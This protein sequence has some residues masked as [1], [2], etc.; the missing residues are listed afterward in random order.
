MRIHRELSK[1]HSQKHLCQWSACTLLFIIPNYECSAN[2]LIDLNID[3]EPLITSVSGDGSLAVG[4]LRK[5][6]SNPGQYQPFKYDLPTRTLTTLNVEVTGESGYA[7]GISYDGTVILG[8]CR[9]AAATY[10]AAKWAADG[11]RTKLD[12]LTGAK[13]N[14]AH[15][16]S[17][18]KKVII[19]LSQDTSGNFRAVTWKNGATTATQLPDITGGSENSYAHG[20]SD[21]GSIIVGTVQSS[22]TKKNLA[23]KW[24]NNTVTSLGTLGGIGSVALSVSGDG[25]VIVGSA[26]TTT[27]TTGGVQ[28][29]HAYM[30]KD[31][32]MI[33]LGTLGGTNSLATAVSG[34]GAVIVGSAHTLDNETHAFQ[35]YD[36]VMKDL[37]TLGGLSSTAAAVSAD[38]KLILGRSQIAGGDWHVFMCYTDF[39]SKKMLD[40]DNTYETLEENHGQLNSLFNLQNMM[41]R[42]ASEH[43]FTEFGKNNIALGVG[44]YVN[45]LQ[46]V[47]SNLATQY[48]GMA[49]KVHPEYRFGIFLDHNFSAHIPNNFNVSHNKLWVGAFIGWRDSNAL[50]SSVKASFG[51]GKQKVTITREK[52][53]NTELGSGESHFEGATAQIEG[54]YGTRLGAGVRVQPFLG[55]QFTRITR[56]EYDEYTEDRVHFPVHYDPVDYSTGVIYLGLGSH[57]ALVDSLHV[58]TRMGMEQNFAAHIDKFSGSIPSVGNFAFEKLNIT[59]TRA[60]A[61]MHVNLELSYLQSLNLILIVN[62]QPLRGVMGFSSDLRYSVGF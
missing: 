18:D 56:D 34:D 54:R 24:E 13:H 48:I 8:A 42:R 47:S 6:G 1:R 40:L 12:G 9:V 17:K 38:G 41:L 53:E 5:L 32:K 51:Y 55:L 62:Q 23:V 50:G 45:A 11:T 31:N 26:N 14:E 37:G 36:G 30:Y 39:A 15:K 44:F 16:I 3:T 46:S 33:D 28:E 27:V 60:F 19:G 58:S 49:Y 7:Y 35:Y 57:V 43:E 61:E 21:D 2:D 25:K 59:K 4:T 52:L 29:T 22:T 10:N 20:V